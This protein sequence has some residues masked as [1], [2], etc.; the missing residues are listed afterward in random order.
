[1]PELDGSCRNAN[2][3]RFAAAA[4]P[5]LHPLHRCDPLV[6]MAWSARMHPFARA[7]SGVS[8]VSQETCLSLV[9][10]L[11]L[12]VC[13]NTRR[14]SAAPGLSPS[15]GPRAASP[16]EPTRRRPLGPPSDPSTLSASYELRLR[17]RPR[18]S[19]PRWLAARPEQA[20]DG[21]SSPRLGSFR[22]SGVLLVGPW[23]LVRR[24]CH[25]ELA[26]VELPAT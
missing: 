14:P 23:I 15:G 5:L 8:S 2:T 4:S 1:M 9:S 26:R 25:I 7:L 22:S 12:A 13:H 18:L 6:A 20:Q 19:P 3:Q 11:S 24:R 17:N 10:S 21:V 16:A